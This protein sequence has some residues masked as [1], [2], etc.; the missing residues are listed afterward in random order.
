MELEKI[1][2]ELGVIAAC[3]NALKFLKGLQKNGLKT[4]KA[5]AT[6][7]E[8]LNEC[9]IFDSSIIDLDS[10]KIYQ[11]KLKEKVR[12]DKKYQA[13]KLTHKQILKWVKL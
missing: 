10:L 6:L 8:Y 5:T 4:E 11:N 7:N 1:N 9:M 3:F 2:K 12:N 13:R